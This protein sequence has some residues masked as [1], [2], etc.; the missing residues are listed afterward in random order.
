MTFS[1]IE[2][3]TSLEVV[4]GDLG[5]KLETA[6]VAR[7]DSLAVHDI[8]ADDPSSLVLQNNRYGIGAK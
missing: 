5:Q 6:E 2:N 1:C 3:H 8:D 7:L 4:A